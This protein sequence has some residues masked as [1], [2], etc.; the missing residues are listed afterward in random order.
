MYIKRLTILRHF[1]S[2]ELIQLICGKLVKKFRSELYADL[3]VKENKLYVILKADPSANIDGNEIIVTH[4]LNGRSFKVHL[5]LAGSDVWVYD[6]VLVH[7]GYQYVLEQYE[8]HFGKLPVTIVDAGANIG[9]FI[10]Y[11]KAVN[12][13]VQIV[14]IE[15]D[16]GNFL[17]TQHNIEVNNLISVTLHQAALWPTK[18]T[19]AVV[20][21]FRDKNEWSFRVEKNSDGTISSLTPNEIVSG[22]SGVVDIFKIDI[23][24]AEAK[25]FEADNDLS[26]LSKVKVIA[27]EIHD[28]FSIRSS[29][30]ELLAKYNFEVTHQGELTVG[31]N[32]QFK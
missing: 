12:P 30:L 4:R 6:Q 31:I 11:F 22:F 8:Y 20:N 26:W 24:G 28:E 18:E 5:R 29:I 19:L 25:L 27:I 15:P 13:D 3:Q 16:K 32:T 7:A 2:K 1:T 10:L 14:A 17:R 21:D 23:E 9:L